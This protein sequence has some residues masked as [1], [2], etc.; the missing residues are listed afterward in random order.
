[1]P[2]YQNPVVVELGSVKRTVT[3]NEDQL[4]IYFVATANPVGLLLNFGDT[5]AHVK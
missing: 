4:V 2:K 5:K 1:M 3:V